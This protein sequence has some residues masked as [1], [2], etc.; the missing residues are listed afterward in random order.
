VKFWFFF[1]FWVSLFGKMD[2]GGICLETCFQPTLLKKNERGAAYIFEKKWSL[3]VMRKLEDLEE[4]EKIL[5]KLENALAPLK[6][7]KVKMATGRLLKVGTYTDPFLFPWIFVARVIQSKKKQVL[8]LAL[9]HEE[10]SELD[11]FSLIDHLQIL[12]V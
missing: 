6:F 2:V 7:A 9:F 8:A 4:A 10:K 3:L 1:F 12:S 11:F 5:E